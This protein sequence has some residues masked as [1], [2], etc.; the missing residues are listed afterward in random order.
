MSEI[1]ICS[2]I[3]AIPHDEWQAMVPADDPRWNWSFFKA[4]ESSAIGPDGFV[5]FV[6]RQ[7]GRRVAILPACWYAGLP[8]E[9]AAGQSWSLEGIR[10][11]WPGFL[12]I[13][14]LI[15]GHPMAEGRLLVAPGVKDVEQET[16]VHAAR[17][18]ARRQQLRWLIFKDFRD[19]ERMQ[20]FP[21][22]LLPPFFAA[23]SM[24]DAVLSLPGNGFEDY[25]AQLKPKARRNLRSKLRK[26][27]GTPGVRI[28]VLEDF[29]HLIPQL[30]PLYRQVYERAEARL[31]LL[32]PEFFSS[33]MDNRELGAVVLACWKEEQLLGFLLCLFSNGKCV[34]LRV[35]LDYERAHELHVYF[36][37]Y[38]ENIRL[39]MARGCRE[40]NFCQTS[41]QAKLELGCHLRPSSH[42][43]THSHPLLRPLARRYMPRMLAQ[44]R[45]S[46]LVRAHLAQPQPQVAD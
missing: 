40:I 18:L 39:A 17:E 15:C 27:E 2:S 3:T 14:A 42:V 7:N 37:L 6:R 26:F 45:H 4:M 16:L 9:V 1:E 36:A 20:V 12:R 44:Y 5:Y 28:E 23:E 33:L 21:G 31:E 19:E 30:L 29:R 34:N 8:L 25:V 11:R 13:S 10:R 41:Y 32:T 46:K 24:P 38:A 35:G 43:M 22:E